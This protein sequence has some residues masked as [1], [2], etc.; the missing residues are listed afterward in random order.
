MIGDRGRRE[1]VSG[2]HDESVY[3]VQRND[4]SRRENLTKA[5]VR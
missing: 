5:A 3:R 4:S 2:R 1:I